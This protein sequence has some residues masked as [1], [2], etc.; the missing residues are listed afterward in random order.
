M[1]AALAVV[2]V[3]DI[4]KTAVYGNKYEVMGSVAISASPA[5]YAA[6]GVV[7]SLA[8]PLIKAGRTPISVSVQGISGVTYAYVPS[9]DATLGKLKILVQDATNNN[10]LK[11]IT[12]GGAIPAAVSGDTI[13][14]YAIWTGQN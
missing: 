6:G 8:H 3:A 12:D 2:S 4:G 14:F 1:A 5:T 11:E 13:N 10:P 7:M 9:T